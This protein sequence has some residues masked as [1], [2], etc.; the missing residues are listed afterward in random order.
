ME[1]SALRAETTRSLRTKQGSR[2]PRAPPRAPIN[3]VVIAIPGVQSSQA[4]RLTR[5]RDAM[6]K[7]LP[8]LAIIT[9]LAGV[10]W[11][12][13]NGHGGRHT[14][15]SGSAETAAGVEARI[16]KDREDI[17][18]AER[19]AVRRYWESLCAWLV[20]NPAVLKS[21]I[22]AIKRHGNTAV[23]LRMQPGKD[24]LT[25]SKRSAVIGST[26]V[27]RRAGTSAAAKAHTARVMTARPRIS[28]S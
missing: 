10:G 19:A 17:S 25:Y 16:A 4:H 5:A 1:G 23:G 21:W 8:T 13:P 14:S 6:R 11:A 22:L 7:S 12:F 26:L 15:P 27:A 24:T 28:G 20:L 3:A 2:L 18:R 9:L